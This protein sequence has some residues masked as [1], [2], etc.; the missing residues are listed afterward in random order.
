M[1][2]GLPA[3]T[4]CTPFSHNDIAA[5]ETLTSGYNDLRAEISYTKT[6]RRASL[7]RGTGVHGGHLWAK[8][9][10]ID[11]IRNSVSFLK[12]EVLI[13]GPRRTPP[14]HPSNFDGA[15]A[16]MRSVNREV[17]VALM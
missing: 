9:C 16:R 7:G 13:A 15:F 10:S 17:T 6:F 14:S 3:S 4:C 11:D 8:I 5:N 12:D 2:T 1:R